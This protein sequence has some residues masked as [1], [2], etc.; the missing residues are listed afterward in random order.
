[1]SL[2]SYPTLIPLD[3]LIKP[4]NG[5]TTTGGTTSGEPITIGVNPAGLISLQSGSPSVTITGN[6]GSATPFVVSVNSA[7]VVSGSANITVTGGS[8]T[9][10]AVVSLVAVPTV[11]GLTINQTATT[12]AANT[13]VN[14]TTAG[15]SWLD[16]TS[17]PSTP[18]PPGPTS[19]IMFG[20]NTGL[21]ETPQ[22][23]TLYLKINTG[24]W[25]NNS[26][27]NRV[28]LRSGSMDP[29]GR[30]SMEVMD[31]NLLLTNPL[32]STQ[33][34]ALELTTD[35]AGTILYNWAAP[36][37]PVSFLGIGPVK[38]SN[39]SPNAQVG[40]ITITSATTADFTLAVP[41]TALITT[42]NNV[43]G[44]NLSASSSPAFFMGY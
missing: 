38:V 28:I 25:S 8:N 24:D 4:G 13:L 17:T 43:T 7:A 27:D 32:T 42:G 18:A 33:T 30:P 22:Q 11:N 14:A 40:V 23:I 10:P 35:P 6:G 29:F 31:L 20:P 19:N 5:V 2:L 15:P 21:V 34:I 36:F 12:P 37:S 44:S 1:M 3:R 26:S 41:S 39:S 9:T 16:P